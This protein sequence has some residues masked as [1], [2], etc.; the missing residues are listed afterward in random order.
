MFEGFKV[1]GVVLCGS[2]RNNKVVRCNSVVGVVCRVVV[3]LCGRLVFGFGV[4][5]RVRGW[6]NEKTLAWA[7]PNQNCRLCDRVL[8][9]AHTPAI[10]KTVYLIL[11]F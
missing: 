7:L 2:A 9:V 11:V 3:V 1:V 8:T 6:G 4:V 5:D 10:H